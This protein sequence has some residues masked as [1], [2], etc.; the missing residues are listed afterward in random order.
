MAAMRELANSTARKAIEK[1]DRRKL[2]AEAF[3]KAA[4]VIIG[5]VGGV[6]LLLLN[7]FRFNMALVGAISGF[8]VALLWGFE[9]IQLNKNLRKQNRERSGR[10]SAS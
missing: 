6:V 2:A 7:G 3:F 8:G 4:V 10:H 1:S 9:A 5:L